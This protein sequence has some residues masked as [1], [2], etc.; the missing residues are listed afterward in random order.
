MDQST[1]WLLT[2]MNIDPDFFAEHIQSWGHNSLDSYLFYL[3]ESDH[4][5]VTHEIGRYLPDL[6]DLHEQT[7]AYCA[8]TYVS[9]TYNFNHVI[10]ELEKQLV[11]HAN[12]HP[13]YIVTTVNRSRTY[14]EYL[15]QHILKIYDKHHFNFAE[16]TLLCVQLFK[17]FVDTTIESKRSGQICQHLKFARSKHQV[18]QKNHFVNFLPNGSSFENNLTKYGFSDLEALKNFLKSSKSKANYFFIYGFSFSSLADHPIEYYDIIADNLRPEH[19]HQI[20]FWSAYQGEW[21]W[22]DRAVVE[23]WIK[24]MAKKVSAIDAD[25][26]LSVAF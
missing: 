3:C 22:T 19:F 9:N 4:S 24:Q 11:L 18:P 12:I 5:L 14:T 2:E 1:L 6:R 21:L 26:F 10:V 7:V 17:Y 13:V 15:H 16:P 8:E 20:L 25:A 23:P